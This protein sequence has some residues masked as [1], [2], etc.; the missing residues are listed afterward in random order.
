MENLIRGLDE[1]SEHLTREE[2]QEELKASGVNIEATLARTKLL[3]ASSLKKE[4]TAWMNVADTNKN[5]LEAAAKK[6]VSWKG[7]ATAEIQEAYAAMTANL[8]G[9][10]VLA[11]RKQ[12]ENLSVEDMAGILDDFERVK[13]KEE[14]QK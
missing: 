14:P 8:T 6:F 9:Q 7:R 4:R 1:H 10:Q 2:V 11:F 13:Q 12:Q 5:A 3:I